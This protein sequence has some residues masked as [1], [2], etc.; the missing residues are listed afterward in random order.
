MKRNLYAFLAGATFAFGLAVSGMSRPSKVRGFLDFFG[1]WDITLLFVLGPAV[2]IYLLGT[3]LAAR[4]YPKRFARQSDPEPLN[5]RFF[6]GCLLFGVGWGMVG[7]CPGPAMVILGQGS[8]PVF[9][10]FGFLLLGIFLA[11]RALE[12]FSGGR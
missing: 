3:R 1:D 5:A 10:F 2:G 8:V 9:L 12:R 11:D 4:L 7:L 6:V